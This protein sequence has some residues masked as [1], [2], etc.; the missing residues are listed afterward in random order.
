MSG[1]TSGNKAPTLMTQMPNRKGNA[2]TH[3]VSHDKGVTA[4]TN[5]KHGLAQPKGAQ[6]APAYSCATSNTSAGATSGRKQGVMVSR[7]AANTGK[8]FG[9]MAEGKSYTKWG[10]YVWIRKSN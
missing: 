1:Y 9:Y 8:N 6:G 10:Q 5:T 7:P 4:M 3:V 2:S